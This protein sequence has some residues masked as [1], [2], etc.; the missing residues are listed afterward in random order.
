MSEAPEAPNVVHIAREPCGFSLT[1]PT[2]QLS[3]GLAPLYSHETLATMHGDA[4]RLA[5][6]WM[7]SLTR[8]P[9]SSWLPSI[10]ALLE[11][12][13]HE[14]VQSGGTFD[15]I[16]EA[17]LYGLTSNVR[18]L[19]LLIRRHQNA[20][21]FIFRL[22]QEILEI[23]F[24]NLRD[25]SFPD[26]TD[27]HSRSIEW[28]RAC[29]HVCRQWRAVSELHLT[30][31]YYILRFDRRSHCSSLASGRRWTSATRRWGRL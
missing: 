5:E 2:S 20:A 18:Q 25:L 1:P 27:K 3:P 9:H 31:S 26:W 29:T 11:T 28:F 4:R 10:R 13:P 22:P 7:V 15:K 14:F 6:E 23:I 12:L 19:G 30:R 16:S 24:L 17:D 21:T 8:T